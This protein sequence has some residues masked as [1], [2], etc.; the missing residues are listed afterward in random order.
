MPQPEIDDVLGRNWPDLRLNLL[1]EVLFLLLL[2]LARL[3]LQVRPHTLFLRSENAEFVV[4][5]WGYEGEDRYFSIELNYFLSFPLLP[6][7]L[8][9]RFTC[10]S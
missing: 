3:Q 4:V 8:F 1:A 2:N 5:S 10:C 7:F 6:N 9:I